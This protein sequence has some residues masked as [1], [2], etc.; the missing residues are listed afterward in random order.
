M[1]SCSETDGILV[2]PIASVTRRASAGEE[3]DLHRQP[4]LRLIVLISVALRVVKL[5]AAHVGIAI[6]EQPLP[7]HF[8][9]VEI[10]QRVVFVEAR[11]ERVVVERNGMLLVGLARQDAQA[12][13]IHRQRAGEGERLLAGLERLQIGDE[14]FVGHDRGGA[15]H[16]GA[17]DG[18]AARILIDDPRHQIL[19]LLAPAFA[20]LGLRIDDH[21]GEKKIVL[22]GE[23]EIVGERLGALGAVLAEHLDAHA[24]ADQRGRQVVRRTPEIAAGLRRPGLQRLAPLHHLVVAARHLPGAVDPAVGAVRAKR[25]QLE[26]FRAGPGSRR[27]PLPSARRCER[28][29]AR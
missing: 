3:R 10:H 12:L 29:G 9:V 11:R 16:L 28:P 21:V 23:I 27:A 20:A 13:G 4:D 8:D 19:I 18:D 5:R 22:R 2:V 26:I 14:H 17:A 6:D 7:R 25:H 15:E 24:L 1:P